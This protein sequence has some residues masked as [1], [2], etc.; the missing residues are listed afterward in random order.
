MDPE[1]RLLVIVEYLSVELKILLI[2]TILGGLS[3]KRMLVVKKLRSSL[4]LVLKFRLLILSLFLLGMN[5]FNDN[6]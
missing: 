1:K 5:F 4:D 3:P 2:C 6:V